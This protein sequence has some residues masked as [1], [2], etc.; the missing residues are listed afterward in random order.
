MTE[1]TT[2][3]AATH[4]GPRWDFFCLWRVNVFGIGNPN[5]AYAQYFDG[6]SFLN[7]LTEMGKCPVFLA[8]SKLK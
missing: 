3:K 8:Y 7:P 6:N 5:D 4:C 1:P 2:H